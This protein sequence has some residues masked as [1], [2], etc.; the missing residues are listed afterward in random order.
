MKTFNK[1]LTDNPGFWNS[2]SY[3]AAIQQ[4]V[5][6]WFYYREIC[7][8]DDNKFSL[9]LKRK[10]EIMYP[11]FKNLYDKQMMLNFSPEVLEDVE[12][13]INTVSNAGLDETIK[14]LNEFTTSSRSNGKVSNTS[15]GTAQNNQTV[16][17]NDNGTNTGTV[18]TNG[19]VGVTSQTNG[20]DKGT[21][22]T[23]S[24]TNTE[25]DDSGTSTDTTDMTVGFTQ[26]TQENNTTKGTSNT[27]IESS[28]YPQSTP[29][30]FENYISGAQRTTSDNDSN[31]TSAATGTTSTKTDGTV[32]RT[33]KNDVDTIQ[34]GTTDT[35]SNTT[36][37]SNVNSDTTSD[38]TVT[39]DLKSSNTRTGTTNTDI[40][41]NDTTVGTSESNDSRTDNGN[42]NVDRNQTSNSNVEVVE[43]M[44]RNGN[45]VDNYERYFS[46]IKGMNAVSWLIGG[47]DVCFIQVFDY[48][49]YD[50]C[51]DNGNTGGGS[52][53]ELEEEVKRLAEQVRINTAEIDANAHLIETVH[54]DLQTTMIQVNEN[55]R[56][57]NEAIANQEYTITYFDI[58]TLNTVP[59][60]TVT[61]GEVLE[62]KEF[63][64]I[65]LPASNLSIEQDDDKYVEFN[66]FS[67]LFDNATGKFVPGEFIDLPVAPEGFIETVYPGR[68]GQH[69]IVY[70]K[71]Y[72]TANVGSYEG[73]YSDF[74]AE[75][76][77]FSPYYSG[78]PYGYTIIRKGE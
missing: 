35:T 30:G 33:H 41:T 9:M 19:T 68:A 66:V 3:P 38:N 6:D 74:K 75:I 52:N 65:K 78:P 60:N 17:I 24:N 58:T 55:T 46:L 25:V 4:Q 21:S 64:A 27:L 69:D 16:D 20:E 50:D 14:R 29:Q 43:H 76:P 53:P 2:S 42:E 37:L 11:Q 40:T 32:S 49:D 57:V 51:Y 71:M 63:Y 23:N 54:D 26:D 67:V 7:S 48:E 34:T 62:F 36:H 31:T 45:F 70:I 1:F 18:K 56:L 61:H 12:R 28:D 8:R 13:T 39:N 72:K 44:I 15:N 73:S 10:L 22:T 5:N 77:Q 47:L 59:I